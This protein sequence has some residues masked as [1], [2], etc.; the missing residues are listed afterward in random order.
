MVGNR[1]GGEGVLGKG[2]ERGM[3]G[4][5]HAGGRRGAKRLFMGLSH[6][7]MNDPTVATAFFWH[8]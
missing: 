3:M 7:K 5:G 4:R 6:C 2:R 8:R 1:E